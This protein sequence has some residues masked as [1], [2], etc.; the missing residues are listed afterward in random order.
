[1]NIKTIPLRQPTVENDQFRLFAHRVAENNI[2]VEKLVI[3]AMPN[4]DGCPKIIGHLTVNS[5]P[6]SEAGPGVIEWVEVDPG[7]RRIGLASAMWNL[8]EQITGRKFVHMPVTKTGRAFA[9]SFRMKPSN[10][11]QESKCQ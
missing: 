6:F 2:Y 7:Y 9:K 10:P 11:Q 1:M 3:T 8:A 5:F 4:D